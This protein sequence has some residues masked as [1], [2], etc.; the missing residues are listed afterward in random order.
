ML[1]IM[2]IGALKWILN[3]S[4]KGCENLLLLGQAI[5]LVMVRWAVKLNYMG[6]SLGF[7]YLLLED[8]SMLNGSMALL[9]SLEYLKI[10]LKK[11]VKKDQLPS[12]PKLQPN[13][14][15]HQNMSHNII[16]NYIYSTYQP[17]LFQH[18][19]HPPTKKQ[20]KKC[21]GNFASLCKFHVRNDN[22]PPS[23]Y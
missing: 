20:Y 6:S 9:P 4:R 13:P 17:H 16:F 5:K 3:N 7:G 2:E 21:S 23:E 18:Q 10:N 8:A 1:W 11:V 14:I 22:N 19:V 15:C 12:V